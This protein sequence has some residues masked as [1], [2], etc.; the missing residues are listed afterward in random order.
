MSKVFI[1]L[2]EI[3]LETGQS[4]TDTWSA[5][6]Q[7]SSVDGRYEFQQQIGSELSQMNRLKQ[8]YRLKHEIPRV[9]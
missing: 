8:L 6:Q 9:T 2:K 1:G 7:V 5:V 4:D 3:M